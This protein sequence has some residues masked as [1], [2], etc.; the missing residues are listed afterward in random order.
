[1]VKQI[2]WSIRAKDDR[3]NILEYWWH[4]NKSKTYSK[5]LDRLFREAIT[6]IM[7]YPQIGKM[8]DDQKARIKIVRDYLIVY[9]V[10]E[11]AIYIL[12]IWDGRRN[13]EK[14]NV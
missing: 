11:K 6:T 8:T 12:A 14:L 10:S 13:P 2:I 7:D 1:M 9:E 5:K 4:R 3:K